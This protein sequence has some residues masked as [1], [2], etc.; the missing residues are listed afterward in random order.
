MGPIKFILILTTFFVI[1]T[2]KLTVLNVLVGLVVSGLV[3]LLNSS[4]RINANSFALKNIPLWFW[5]ILVLIKEVIVSNFQV[6]QIVLSRTMPINPHV[7]DYESRL[8]N[9]FLLTVYANVI[10]LTPGTMTVD[11]DENRMKIHCLS[12]SYAS[13]LQDSHLERILL[14]IEG[15]EARV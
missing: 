4:Q 15:R 7:V 14:Q 13:G 11:I 5:F 3:V 2:E 6:A 8:R 1:L 10:T 12:E 9:D